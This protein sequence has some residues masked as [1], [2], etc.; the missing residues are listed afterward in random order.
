MLHVG[1]FYKVAARLF[2]PVGGSVGLQ[3]L[4]ESMCYD[5][6]DVD[7]TV[8]NLRMCFW[9]F[10][11]Q[12]QLVHALTEV[13]PCSVCGPRPSFLVV[14]GLWEIKCCLGCNGVFCQPSH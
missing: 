8:D 9:M 13:V 5:V 12:V 10:L 6:I 7:I 3:H 1:I 4:L 14:D 2:S 11:S